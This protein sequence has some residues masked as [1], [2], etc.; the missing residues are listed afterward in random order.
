MQIIPLQ[1]TPNQTLTV[2]LANQPCRINV[3]Q[4]ST[5]LFVDLYVNDAPIK[6][7]MVAWNALRLIRF[8]YLGF[9]GDLAFFDTLASP[10]QIPPTDP[11]YTGLGAQYVLAYLEVNDLVGVA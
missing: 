5:G 1:A 11:V 8:D 2:T 4:Q 10:P 9:T 7:G 3:Y 6:T